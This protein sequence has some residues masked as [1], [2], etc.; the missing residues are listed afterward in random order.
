M[1]SE[2]I[3]RKAF[4]DILLELGMISGED[5]ADL[6]EHHCSRHEM[7]R[8]LISSGK[9][10]V[11]QMCQALSAEFNL[12][13][14]NLETMEKL[15][16]PEAIGMISFRYA[17][18]N[19]VVPLKREGV[20]LFVATSEPADLLIKEQLNEMTELEIIYVI[21][22]PEDIERL[23]EE[24]NLKFKRKKS[25]KKSEK[26]LK[27]S[28]SSSASKPDINTYKVKKYATLAFLVIV[29]LWLIFFYDS[30]SEMDRFYGLH[31]DY[32]KALQIGY[33]GDIYNYFHE[34]VKNEDV[35]LFIRNKGFINSKIT[36][37]RVVEA[38]E[39]E[40]GAIIL[41]VEYD[42][43][44]AQGGARTVKFDEKWISG[45]KGWRQVL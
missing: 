38:Y 3:E 23:L 11:D 32:V 17:S 10:T 22:R 7:A 33:S 16:S 34:Q 41:K 13:Y 25:R 29:G 42:V 35:D 31:E 44:S 21:A 6:Q 45:E 1:N 37:C 12:D 27:E 18:K 2:F 20:E 39:T 26:D 30:S 14:Y 8:Q 28:K 9:I 19:K 15:I 4:G 5:L 43:V 36:E 40:E 24:H